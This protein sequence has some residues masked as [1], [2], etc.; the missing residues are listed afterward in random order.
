MRRRS[1][2]LSSP[3][4]ARSRLPHAPVLTDFA[5]AEVL[6]HG[7]LATLYLDEAESSALDLSD[8]HHLEFEYMQHMRTVIDSRFAR[9][10]SLRVLHLGAAG[11]ALA[12]ALEADRPHSRQLAVE[13]DGELARRVREWFDLPASPRLRIRVG[14]A[15][16]AL[17][18]TKAQWD[19]VIRDAFV[20]RSVP[21]HL[22]T[23]ECA[24]RAKD[25]L[26]GGLYLLNATAHSSA[27]IASEVA[28]L[29]SVFAHLIAIVD[30]AVLKGRRVG[31][32]VFAASEESFDIP[33]IERAL[34]RLPMPA[35]L[36]TEVDLSRRATG[37]NILYDKEIFPS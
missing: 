28:T 5:Q 12:R 8:P 26:K 2:K 13:L 4:D 32:I 11:C 10:L 16:E 18:A 14:E 29:R 24:N 27:D 9:G 35:S 23:V 19:V 15:R 34:R 37:V 22:R 3:L 1:L 33:I 6:L 30:P 25:V 7:D 20:K 21:P 31:N 17:Q 36:L